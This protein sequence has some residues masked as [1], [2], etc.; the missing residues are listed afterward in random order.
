[1]NY[2]SR[3]VAS[4]STIERSKSALFPNS[5]AEAEEYISETK[6]FVS[7]E[8]SLVKRKWPRVLELQDI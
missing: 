7:V 5:T 1:M 6:V 4:A 3:I 8:Y 2:R